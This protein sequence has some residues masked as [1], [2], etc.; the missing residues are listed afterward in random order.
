M[1][2]SD[3]ARGDQGAAAHECDLNE[4]PSRDVVWSDSNLVEWHFLR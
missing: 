4:Q 2:D 3:N 1:A